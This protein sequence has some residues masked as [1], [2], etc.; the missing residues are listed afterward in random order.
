MIVLRI[1]MVLV[2]AAMLPAPAGAQA[3]R[4]LNVVYLGMG[5]M[6]NGCQAKPP[7]TQGTVLAQVVRDR[8]WTG[9]CPSRDAVVAF[10]DT[11][12]GR[13]LKEAG[14]N[15]WGPHEDDKVKQGGSN[16]DS[17]AFAFFTVEDPIQVFQRTDDT[18]RV[19][20]YIPIT[21][22]V[23]S[24]RNRLVIFN[25]T[26]IVRLEGRDAAN[27]DP[28]A[29]AIE[30]MRLDRLDKAF[31]NALSDLLRI[32]LGDEGLRIALTRHASGQ[33]NDYGVVRVTLDPKKDIEVRVPWV[34]ALADPDAYRRLAALYLTQNLASQTLLIPPYAVDESLNTK[35]ADVADMIR[36]HS[37]IL[38]SLTGYGIDPTSA[39][40]DMG[41]CRDRMCRVPDHPFAKPL[42]SVA[43][44]PRTSVTGKR[45]A[46][47]IATD[48]YAVSG[49][50]RFLDAIGEPCRNTDAPK[51]TRFAST[52]EVKWLP[53][54]GSANDK[55]KVGDV[56]YYEALVRAVTDGA[57]ELVITKKFGEIHLTSCGGKG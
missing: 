33:A 29:F 8:M 27:A 41:G 57:A 28:Q 42:W 10:R 14:I 1:V 56:P 17:V 12:A 7:E 30:F 40:G 51:G 32:A 45:D 49:A 46:A 26:H 55:V 9:E 53:G 47:G 2:L 48:S 19:F 6:A 37:G 20:V 39:P 50:A 23:Y 24:F 36:R 13:K 44:N 35:P 34:K 38:F 11:P 52:R 21:F 15:V 4:Q 16:P 3:Q 22:H 54:D 43:F 25:R 5:G 18:V 31:K